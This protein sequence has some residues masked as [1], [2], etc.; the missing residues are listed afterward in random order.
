M[1]M[2]PEERK[3]AVGHGGGVAISRGARRCRAHVS[4]VIKGDRRDVKV[5]KVAV[6]VASKN[7]GREVT[8][9]EMWG[10]EAPR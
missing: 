4:Y 6:K 1:A 10:E 3:R 5:Q 2:S 9:E 7:L 8:Y